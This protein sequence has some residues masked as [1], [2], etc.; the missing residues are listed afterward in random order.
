LTTTGDCTIGR[1]LY[2]NSNIL[3]KGDIKG[4]GGG[5]FNGEYKYFLTYEEEGNREGRL[6]LSSGGY[7]G[8][9]VDLN[10]SFLPSFINH[11][12]NYSRRDRTRQRDI[13]G[14]TTIPI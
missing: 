14:T 11:K 6:L 5:S 7:S 10:K 2:V 1:V 4:T 3:T 9:I 8:R 13:T 12:H